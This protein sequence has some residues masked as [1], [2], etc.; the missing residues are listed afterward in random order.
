MGKIIKTLCLA[1]AVLVALG[2]TQLKKQNRESTR[3]ELNRQAEAV[4]LAV[5]A[6]ESEEITHQKN[7]VKWYNYNLKL[8]TTGLES[9]YETILNF[10][11]GRMAVLGVPE[12]ELR[13]AIYHG[14]GGTV[15]HD[16]ATALPLGGR[17]HHTILYLT[18][19]L[20]WAEGMS[21]YIDCLGQR[22]TYRVESVETVD[23]LRRA[24]FTGR[25]GENLLTLVF[26]RG[27]THTLIRCT[28]CGELVLRQGETGARFPW[29][30]PAAALPALIL[31]WIWRGKRPVKH[32]R[33]GK[34]WGLYRKNRGKAKLF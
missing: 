33:K 34:N 12:W 14:S 26:D 5:D 23:G 20:P 32:E 30:A 11:G 22:L 15:N 13:M 27:E 17:E 19:D 16:P 2:L 29:A 21:L 3:R 8:G 31:V 7:L 24:D 1:L 18:E 10:G 9:A 4:E 25:A 6:L 28:R